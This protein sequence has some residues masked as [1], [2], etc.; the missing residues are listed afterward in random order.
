MRWLIA[1]ADGRPD[2]PS[3]ARQQDVGDFIAWHHATHNI[4][5][6]SIARY[7]TALHQVSRR[8]GFEISSASWGLAKQL[9]RGMKKGDGPERDCSNRKSPIAVPEL[10]RLVRGTTALAVTY[11]ALFLSALFGMMR[12]G[13]YPVEAKRIPVGALSLPRT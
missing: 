9:T 3:L 11:R 12:L 13:A 8:R 2:A 4:S 6:S 10:R 7:V 5:G 1:T